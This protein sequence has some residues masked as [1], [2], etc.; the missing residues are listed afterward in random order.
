[1]CS[2]ICQSNLFQGVVRHLTIQ[3][4]LTL[5]S[6]VLPHL[7]LNRAAGPSSQRMTEYLTLLLVHMLN[8]F[9][10]W[11]LDSFYGERNVYWCT[12]AWCTLAAIICNISPR[13]VIITTSYGHL[14]INIHEIWAFT[15]THWNLVS[16]QIYIRLVNI[17]CHVFFCCVFLN[18]TNICI[19]MPKSIFFSLLSKA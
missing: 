8:R 18:C 2:P 1:M 15:Q 4:P 9:L 3:T 7:Q 16:H 14:L 6:R 12:V 10:R 19:N 17:K 13:L 5:T 11:N